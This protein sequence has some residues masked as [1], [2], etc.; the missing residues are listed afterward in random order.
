MGSDHRIERVQGHGGS[1]SGKD[2][3]LLINISS[4]QEIVKF[5]EKITGDQLDIRERDRL[6]YIVDE[7]WVDKVTANKD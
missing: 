7:Q 2:C 5:A 6:Y 1:V 4:F 3:T